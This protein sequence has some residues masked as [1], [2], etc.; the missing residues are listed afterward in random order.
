MDLDRY[1]P[2]SPE[3]IPSESLSSDTSMLVV[4]HPTEK[5]AK[6]EPISPE[7]GWSQIRHASLEHLSGWLGETPPDDDT[8]VSFCHVSDQLD[9]EAAL[10]MAHCAAQ[11]PAAVFL[12]SDETLH[13]SDDPSIPAG[14]RQNRTAITPFRLLCRG[15]LGGLVTI[16]W[17][18]LQQLT[19]P[20]STGSLHAFLLDLALQ[21]CRRGDSIAH[22]SEALVQRCIRANPTVPD[23]A[24]PAD[25]HCWSPELRAEI[26]AI[27]QSTAQA[28]WSQR[29]AHSN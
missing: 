28:F 2:P 29:T 9:P 24:S 3:P 8:L 13:W 7:Q 10:R 16:R 26:L 27:T 12:T 5:E 6:A 18:L 4:L 17:S 19:L 22:C 11:H 23:V 21:V 20:T 1:Q 15:C 25:R 14:N